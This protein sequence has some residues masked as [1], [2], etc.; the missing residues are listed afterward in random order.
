MSAATAAGPVDDVFDTRRAWLGAIA[1]L[2]LTLIAYFPA[3]QAG[4][5]WDDDQYVSENR[6]LQEG[7]SGLQRIWTPRQTPQYYPVVFSMF[8]LEHQVWGL[9]PHGYHIINI[10]LHAINA[11]LVWRLAGMLKMPWA[12]LIG[13]TFALH[14]VHVESVAWITE[15]KNT[16]SGLF[17]LLAAIAYLKFDAGSD[18]RNDTDRPWRMY[19]AALVC[20]V[21]ALLSKSVTCSLPA[22]LIL[23]MLWQRKGMTAWR[24]VPLIPLLVIGLLLA[25]NTA[26]I[27][28]EHVGAFGEDFEFSAADRLIIA[29]R[30]LLFYAGKIIWPWPIIFTY[31]RWSIDDS[32][33]WQYLWVLSIIVVAAMLSVLYWR[34]VRGPGLAIAFFAGTVFPALG[35]VNIYPMMFSFVA[36]HFQYLASLGIITLAVAGL[37]LLLKSRDRIALAAVVILLPLGAITF[38]Q[39][40][41]YQDA[42]TLYR[43]VIAKNPEAFM[44][45]NNLATELL[46]ESEEAREAGQPEMAEALEQQAAGHLAE[47]LRIKPRYPQALQNM[48][49]L[50][51]RHGEDE[52]SLKLAQQAL[53]VI[54]ARPDIQEILRGSDR[55]RFAP[56]ADVFASVARLQAKTNRLEEARSN[57]QEAIA[58]NPGDLSM[59]SEFARLLFTIGDVDGSAAQYETI[60]SAAPGDIAT[61]ASLAVLREKQNRFGDA[62]DLLERAR[63]SAGAQADR[64]AITLRLIRL[65]S[66]ASNPSARDTKRAVTLAEELVRQT[67]RQDPTLLDVLSDVLATDGRIEQ[68]IATGEEATMLAARLGLDELA[69]RIRHRI[70]ALRKGVPSSAP[71]ASP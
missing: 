61:L 51:A 27:E 68:A 44:A 52:Q 31:E 39:C 4:Y 22:A 10:V 71:A 55:P 70:D 40:Y 63:Q 7:W 66:A 1:I 38:F 41:A 16:L 45:H 3:M 23:M 15:R 53:D 64:V 9:D 34:G 56:I 30:A 2:L 13:A 5:V 46:R 26:N 60:L 17:Y 54:T 36:D 67:Q 69:Q 50:L 62:R 58:W 49:D 6:L 32:N 42:Q 8:W 47:A 33:P 24:L 29:S 20:F 65:L 11:V 21:L 14:P 43:D 19:V 59:R 37:G 25:L 12:W 28:R 18:T 57:Y 35:F 48:S